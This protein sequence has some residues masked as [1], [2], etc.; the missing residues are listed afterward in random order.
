LSRIP[1]TLAARSSNAS[2]LRA[3]IAASRT[4]IA[5]RNNPPHAVSRRF[6]PF[7]EN[8][9]T[10]S[11]T[12]ASSRIAAAR[13]NAFKLSGFDEAASSVDNDRSALARTPAHSARSSRRFRSAVFKTSSKDLSDASH[14]PRWTSARARAARFAA[15][16]LSTNVSN[17][18][19]A[20]PSDLSPPSHALEHV[21]DV[22]SCTRRTPTCAFERNETSVFASALDYINSLFPNCFSSTSQ[23]RAPCETYPREFVQRGHRIDGAFY[24]RRI[25]RLFRV[26]LTI[27]VRALRVE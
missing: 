22:A 18:R 19:V 6:D 10:H 13:R 9:T 21:A 23:T 20:S 4:R 2:D 27:R 3:K 8:A 11:N 26:F 17:L 16:R 12:S 15:A 1:G 14:A 7:D 24:R 5:S 25:H